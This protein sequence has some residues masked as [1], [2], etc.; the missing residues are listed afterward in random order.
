MKRLTGKIKISERQLQVPIDMNTEQHNNKINALLSIEHEYKAGLIEFKQYMEEKKQIEEFYSPEKI[1]DEELPKIDSNP[2]IK[3]YSSLEDFFEKENPK[4]VP[5][6]SIK[7]NNL[8]GQIVLPTKE[9]NGKQVIDMLNNTG[10]M[11]IEETKH[12]IEDSINIIIANSPID[13]SLISDGKKTF[14][15]LYNRIQELLDER[16]GKL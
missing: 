5:N 4:I 13:T 2:S 3:N 8:Y 14:G 12:P 16:D 10:Y 11:F 7:S 1:L 9:T 6:P 15:Q